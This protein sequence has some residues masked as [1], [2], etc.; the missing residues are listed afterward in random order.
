MKKLVLL[1]V[2]GITAPALAQ[3]GATP[4]NDVNMGVPACVS[5]GTC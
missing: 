5:N 1:A 4:R 3:T 2:L